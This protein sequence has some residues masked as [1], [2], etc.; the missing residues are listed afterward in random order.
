M[1]PN[2][3][4]SYSVSESDPWGPPLQDPCPNTERVFAPLRE[5]MNRAAAEYGRNQMEV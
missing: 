2:H 1:H 4:V 3:R 5:A